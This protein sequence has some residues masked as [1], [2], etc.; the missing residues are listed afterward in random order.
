MRS[1]ALRSPKTTSSVRTS[2]TRTAPRDPE[3]LDDVHRIDDGPTEI[4]A[5][6]RRRRSG[7]Y[8]FKVTVR[9]DAV[10]RSEDEEEGPSRSKE[11]ERGGGGGEDEGR[12]AESAAA[13]TSSSDSSDST[14]NTSS[15]A[16]RVR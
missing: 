13:A 8:N 12:S 1:F 14:R 6:H 11:T 9:V 2:R 5:S 10:R 15:S 16:A 4:S 3:V 7:S